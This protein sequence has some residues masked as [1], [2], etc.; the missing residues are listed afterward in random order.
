MFFLKPRRD[1][2]AGVQEYQNTPGAVL[3]DV[4]TPKEF[5]QVR[6]PGSVNVPLHRLSKAEEIIPSFDTPVFIYCV[7][8]ARADKAVKRL[9]RKGYT[10]LQC[11][12]GIN[13]YSGLAERG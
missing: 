12:G 9:A 3:I 2:N 13:R 11:I 8:G 5:A 10:N 4:R 1:I 7:N 6:I